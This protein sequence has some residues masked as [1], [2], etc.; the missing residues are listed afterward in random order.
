[1]KFLKQAHW[2]K[3]NKSY[4]WTINFDNNLS[5]IDNHNDC[6]YGLA[7]VLL[8]YSNAYMAGISEAKEY[9]NETFELLEEKYWES[10]NNLY[11]DTYNM[12]GILQ[13]YR[14]QNPNMHLVEAFIS[15]FDA[16]NDR[17]Y[18]LKAYLV[19]ETVSCKLASI[20]K[21]NLIW[22]HFS[23]SSYNSSS[24]WTIDNEYNINNCLNEDHF[25]PYGYQPGHLTEWSKLLIRLE[26]R[27]IKVF[28]DGDEDIISN[29]NTSWIVPRARELF[30]IAMINGWDD[31]FDGLVYSFVENE[32]KN[33]Q[34]F[35]NDTRS[36][37][38]CD[39]NKYHW[40]QAESF[41]ASAV[42]FKR[43]G[44]S[45]YKDYY[46]K[47]WKYVWNNFIDHKNGAWY[48]TLNQDNSK[49]SNNKSPAGKVDYHSIGSCHDSIDSF[50]S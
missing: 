14:G 45:K 31:E 18:L 30:D 46:N 4:S 34:N 39:T 50:I 29:L 3:E 11:A 35:N 37:K 13:D 38:F 32:N 43:T 2:N 33:D 28:N 41:S 5:T 49:I 22:E 8:A 6:C 42:L 19:T 48:C 15:A 7:F 9:I 40:V 12:N 17:K 20:D 26:D 36:F 44:D 25:R 47:I 21:F 1:L 27:T 24:L 23:S 10:N 16:T